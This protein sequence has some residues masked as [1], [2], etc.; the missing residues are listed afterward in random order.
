MQNNLYS[1]GR[2]DLKTKKGRKIRPFIYLR[3][4]LRTKHKALK[5]SHSQVLIK[6]CQVF[7]DR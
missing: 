3:N 5:G 6:L 4:D 2:N 1:S 7:T